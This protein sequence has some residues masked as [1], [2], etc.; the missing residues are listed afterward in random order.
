MGKLGSTL[1]RNMMLK[2]SS[3]LALGLTISPC[4]RAA[5]IIAPVSMRESRSSPAKLLKA[6]AMVMRLNGGRASLGLSGSSSFSKS[7]SV[8]LAEEAEL[9]FTV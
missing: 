8:S 9:P 2:A 1:E 7:S 6:S 5:S 3:Q 4:P